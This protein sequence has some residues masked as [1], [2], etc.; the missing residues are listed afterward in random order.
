M[1]LNQELINRVK[2]YFGLNLYETRIWLSLLAKGIAS[3]G[4]ISSISGVPRPRVYDVLES[5]EKKGFVILKLGK[6]IKYVA[7]KPNIVLERL[8]SN[9]MSDAE[10]KIK[11]IS[12]ITE[13]EEFREIERIYKGNINYGKEEDVFSYLKGKVNIFHYLRE[14]I[15][16]S[17]KKVVICDDANTIYRKLPAFK[18]LIK[19]ISNKKIELVIVLY[20]EDKKIKIIQENLGI[21]IRKSN[22]NSKFFIVD[23]SEILIYIKKGDKIEEEAIW[24]KSEVFAKIFSIIAEKRI[25]FKV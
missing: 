21:K 3:A 4:E 13:T 23:D 11:K 5:L 20:G 18:N 2:D 7:V 24:L 6:P 22:I 15:K 25:N 10:D 9:I 12:K 17:T 1:I 16:K 8:K 14:M 19:E